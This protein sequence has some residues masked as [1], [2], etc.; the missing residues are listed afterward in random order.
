MAVIDAFAA[1]AS[2]YRDA[3]DF[4][5]KLQYRDLDS[6]IHPAAKGRAD[7]KYVKRFE[8]T[9]LGQGEFRTLLDAMRRD[10]FVTVCTPFDE[11]SVARIEE[12]SVDVVKIA[13]CSFTDWP[14]LERVAR[15]NKPVIASTASASLQEIDAVVSFFPSTAARI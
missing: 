11:P 6:F 2:P 4:A 5:F 9:R 3:F 1:A 10:G 13:S 15:T 7:V 12:D 8:E 14:L